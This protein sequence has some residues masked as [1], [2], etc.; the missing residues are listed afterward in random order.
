MQDLITYLR[1]ASSDEEMQ[2]KLTGLLTPSEVL[3]MS[4]RLQIFAMLKEG[5]PQREIAKQLGVGIATV[6]RGS[7]AL[8]ELEQASSDKDEQ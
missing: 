5:V 1:S 7:R 6:T 8:K 2:N 4:K 3:E